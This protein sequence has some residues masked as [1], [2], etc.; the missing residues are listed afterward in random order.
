ML[1][2]EMIKRKELYTNYWEFDEKKMM[3]K[4]KALNG[5]NI[6]ENLKLENHLKSIYILYLILQFKEL[7]KV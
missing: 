1:N 5:W 6:Q 4:K 3:K 2:R 7:F